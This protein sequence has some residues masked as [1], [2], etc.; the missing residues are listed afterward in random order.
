LNPIAAW[1]VSWFAVAIFPL[2][3]NVVA[4][5]G[6]AAT[7]PAV[8][9][10]GL[11]TGLSP[12]R[13]SGLPHIDPSIGS[14]FQPLGKR[15]ADELLHGT[16]PWWDPDQGIG[17]PLAGGMIAGSFFP[18]TLLQE[19]P[20]GQTV[21]EIVVQ[22][23]TGAFTLL[24][25]RRIGLDAFS[26]VAGALLF[27]SNGTFAWLGAGWC[28]PMPFLPLLLYGIELVFGTTMRQRSIGTALVAVAVGLSVTAAM[29][30]I[31][32]LNGLFCVA[33][34]LVRLAGSPAST[35]IRRLGR[36][37]VGAAAGLL[38]AS[39]LIVAFADYLHLSPVG[40]HAGDNG[41]DHLVESA[42]PQSFLPY[43]W[44]PIFDFNVAEIRPIW[45]S[46]GGY[47]GVALSFL[48]VCGAFGR[49]LRSLRILA[50]TWI[51]VTY[52]ATIGLPLAQHAIVLIPGVKFVA[53]YRYFD[54]S[55]EFAFAFLAAIFLSDVRSG[56]RTI[57]R[58]RYV[59]ATLV[60]LAL[61]AQGSIDA[62]PL[63]REVISLPALAPWFW[64]SLAFGSALLVALWAAAL[65]LRGGRQIAVALATL[66]LLEATT[67]ALIPTF[68]SPATGSVDEAPI[69]FLRSHLGLQRFFELG[70]IAPSYG[71]YF[72]VAELNYIGF[73]AG[74]W[75]SYVT[76]HL[77][78]N[79]DPTYFDGVSPA[80]GPGI[81]GRD[82]V[83]RSNVLAFENL[84]VK[85]VVH[86][87]GQAPLAAVAGEALP[88]APDA[89]RA[90]RV[91]ADS[92]VEIDELPNPA[93]YFSATGCRLDVADRERLVARCSEPSVLTRRE[94][95]LPGWT[96]RVGGIAADIVSADVLQTVALPAGES[97]VTFDFTPPG[98]TYAYVG[99][100]FGMLALDHGGACA[101]DRCKPDRRLEKE[102]HVNVAPRRTSTFWWI[103]CVA[104]ALKLYL[105]SG[106]A[107]NA[108]FAPHDYT[109]FLGHAQSI[110]GGRW[111]GTYDDLTLIK[112][113]GLPLYLVAIAKLGMPV[114]LAH[115]LLF[116]L[117]ALSACLA[118]R[119][120]VRNDVALGIA[121]VALLFDPFTYSA[122]AWILNR[123]QT[124]DSLAIFVVAGCVGAVVRARRSVLVV[125]PWLIL[126]GLATTALGM[127]REDTIWIVVP[128]VIF[129]A[130]Y[131]TFVWPGA[132]RTRYV[133]LGLIAVPSLIF[134]LSIA[135]LMSINGRV[136]GWA[137]TVETTSPVFVSAY[138]SISR[139]VVPGV[140]NRLYPAPKVARDEAYAVS[141]AAAELKPFFDPTHDWQSVSCST[142]SLCDDV[143]AGWFLWA[144]RDSVAGAGYYASGAKAR[145]FYIRFSREL[146]AACDAGK[147]KC[148]AK[149]YSLA[150]TIHVSDAPGIVRYGTEALWH[151]A[152]F[153]QYAAGDA[154]PLDADDAHVKDD[155]AYVVGSFAGQTH[156]YTGWILHDRSSEV[157]VEDPNARDLLDIA[158]SASPDLRDAFAKSPYA[159]DD[160]DR[161][162]FTISTSCESACFVTVREAGR[163]PVSI[164]L[165]ATTTD[166][167]RSGVDYHLDGASIDPPAYYGDDIKARGLAQIVVAYKEIVRTWAL[168]VAFAVAIRLYRFVRGKRPKRVRLVLVLSGGTL[169]TLAAH[170]AVLGVVSAVSFYALYPEYE[171]A[172]APLLLLFL[173]IETAVEGEIAL[174]LIRRKLPHP[175]V[176]QPRVGA[177]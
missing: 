46:V 73:V 109:N 127:T 29:I 24:L 138:Q 144:F 64:R 95:F 99:F 76:K 39:P 119:P 133:R 82:E 31:A 155:Y 151:A 66:V 141:P 4:L 21:I 13:V 81:P 88:T 56:V 107:I 113:P 62:A 75:E 106:I 10:S 22:M 12:G 163:K 35:R 16:L 59:T 79:V 85:Y 101:H 32:F 102:K 43:L 52:A 51:V 77:D 130:A 63:V 128:I 90:R 61:F 60:V 129:L 173:G 58:Y 126:A 116:A 134:A 166:V 30:E 78:A 86:A 143:S 111:F 148:R 164:P 108:H 114:P 158:F 1:R 67:N 165:D 96:A 87:V 11:G 5:S 152:T 68:A 169:A 137:T 26:S 147:L 37:F 27:E 124:I 2:L 89:R 167:Q 49:S 53:Y 121:F 25:L 8:S 142:L 162:R 14:S 69:R 115:Q 136:Y 139:I 7:D 140:N 105:T 150:P 174:R 18:L 65:T 91:Y 153:D 159:A 9:Y 41:F 157:A 176:F 171:V 123:S 19:L 45:G 92:M 57:E 117:A 80:K 110:L 156:V 131:G 122:S 44:G 54:A 154:E 17:L 104:I 145:A 100:A 38:L 168:V 132:A 42:L 83:L 6:L 47:A 20:N 3:L 160:L 33:W 112:G 172:L 170:A 98:V 40:P 50:V 72:D 161:S 36:L 48:A 149:S 28:Y 177:S 103:A 15:S 135:E 146:D 118:I 93:P 55:R 23:L 97:N 74:S 70:P 175:G 84:G 120:I 94:F 71:S 125:L 34:A